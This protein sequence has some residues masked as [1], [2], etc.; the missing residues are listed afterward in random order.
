MVHS[1]RCGCGSELMSL[2]PSRTGS[3]CN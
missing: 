2:R 1:P 3:A